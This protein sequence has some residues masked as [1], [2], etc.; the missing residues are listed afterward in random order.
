MWSLIV[1]LIENK[2]LEAYILAEAS[3]I[4]VQIELEWIKNQ[5]TSQWVTT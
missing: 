3:I 1:L 4:R 5:N 2:N